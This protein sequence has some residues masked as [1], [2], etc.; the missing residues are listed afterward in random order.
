MK[1]CKSGYAK[2]ADILIRNKAN[3]SNKDRAG[4]NALDIAIDEGH[5]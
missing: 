1:A 5:E 2:V 4:C 3:V